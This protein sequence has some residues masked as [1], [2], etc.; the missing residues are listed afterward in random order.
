MI[1]NMRKIVAHPRAT[2]RMRKSV[3]PEKSFLP[4]VLGITPLVTTTRR[5]VLVLSGGVPESCAFIFL[6]NED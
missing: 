6:N 4:P 5:V 1:R 2:A 3:D